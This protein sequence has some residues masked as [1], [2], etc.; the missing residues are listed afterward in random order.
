ME[1]KYI[2]VNG[3]KVYYLKPR[4]GNLFL[5]AGIGYGGSCFPKDT[6]ALHWLANYHDYELKTIKAAIEVNESQKIKLIKKSRKYYESLNGLTV[7]VLG[8]TFKAGTDDLRG[9]PSLDN[10]PILLDEGAIIKVW[11]PVGM[12]NLKKLFPVEVKYCDTIDETLINADICFIFTDWPEIKNYSLKKFAEL[13]KNPI[14][15]DGGNC[16]SLQEAS[17]ANIIY[18]SIGRKVVF[19]KS[20]SEISRS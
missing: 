20:F 7:A 8:L 6:K 1:L 17:E 10:I 18:D 13:M 4:I 12:N 9:A 3:V 14:V 16:Y 19:N 15:L 11:D 2:I 5:K